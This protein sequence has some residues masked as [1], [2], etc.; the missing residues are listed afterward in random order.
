M[1]AIDQL[2]KTYTELLF[3]YINRKIDEYHQPN[4]EG[5]SAYD[6][7]EAILRALGH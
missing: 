4:E 2:P 7:D 3:T 6:M 5:F 1:G